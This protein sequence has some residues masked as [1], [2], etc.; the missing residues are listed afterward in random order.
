MLYG[1]EG[2]LSPRFPK[3]G[4]LPPA[5]KAVGKPIILDSGSKIEPNFECCFYLQKGLISSFAHG[6][7]GSSFL[8]F[9]LESGTM[10][11][12]SDILGKDALPAT[13][14]YTV[15]HIEKE[16]KLIRFDAEEFCKVVS[17]DVESAHYVACSV[18]LK[19]HAFHYLYYESKTRSVASQICILI[20]SFARQ[21]GVKTAGATLIDYPLTHRMIAEM[22]GA[23]RTT[24]S[25]IM[26][27]L[28]E[29]NVLATINDRYCVLSADAL[30]AQARRFS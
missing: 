9:L 12:E 22:L 16:S 17:S 4:P 30:L 2:A 10:F 20:M 15:F 1:S 3:S 6:G 25:K 29:R 8:S 23:N 27:Q 26:R 21:Y 18:S 19:M 5:L 24:V 7:D 13:D 28:K 11:L 14:M